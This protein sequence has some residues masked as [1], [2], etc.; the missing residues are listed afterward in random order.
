MCLSKSFSLR[1][2]FQIRH[3]YRWLQRYSREWRLVDTIFVLSL[4]ASLQLACISEIGVYTLFWSPNFCH[5]Y[6]WELQFTCRLWQA[7]LTFV[8][9]Q[10]YIYFHTLK[11]VEGLDS[12]HSESR[13]WMSSFPLEHWLGLAHPPLQGWGHIK[14]IIGHLN[15]H[16][17]L[18]DNLDL[19]QDETMR[20][21]FYSRSLL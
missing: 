1:G 13:C 8:V 6:P 7:G 11:S 12:K 19:G 9:P 21:I 5:C 14:D 18:R 4:S 16:K 3:T 10:D 2:R 20:F 15:N 17:C